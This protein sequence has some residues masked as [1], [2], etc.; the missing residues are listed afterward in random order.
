MAP[1]GSCEGSPGRDSFFCQS[2]TGLCKC[3][4]NNWLKLLYQLLL[5]ST[6]DPEAQTA[7][8]LLINYPQLNPNKLINRLLVLL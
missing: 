2:I 1:E 8:R 3:I 5:M 4:S 7:H 6:P